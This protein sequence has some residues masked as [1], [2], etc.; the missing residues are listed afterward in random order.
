MALNIAT[1][2]EKNSTANTLSKEFMLK[3]HIT[4]N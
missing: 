2:I 4:V 1:K 3:N